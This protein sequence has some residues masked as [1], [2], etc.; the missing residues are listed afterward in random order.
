MLARELPFQQITNL[1]TQADGWRNGIAAAI[2]ILASVALVKGRD[3]VAQLAIEWRGIIVGVVI[4]GF[5]ALMTSLLLAV[6]VAQGR[7]GDKIWDTGDALQEWTGAEVLRGGRMLRWAAYLAAAGQSLLIVSIAVG[8]LAPSTPSR[9]DSLVLVRTDGDTVCGR[10]ASINYG[11]VTLETGPAESGRTWMS[12]TTA[13][14]ELA[15]VDGC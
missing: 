14:T 3:E 12:P 8:W 1:R 5:A 13:V 7:P 11:I 15:P 9:A 4:T 2:T 10:L 6:R